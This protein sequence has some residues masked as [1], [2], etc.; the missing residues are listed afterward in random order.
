VDDAAVVAGLVLRDLLLL[1][2]DEQ[3]RTRMSQ[4]ELTGDREA[5]DAGPDDDNVGRPVEGFRGMQG[6]RV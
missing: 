1:L 4:Q 2:E 5:E 6:R 3:P